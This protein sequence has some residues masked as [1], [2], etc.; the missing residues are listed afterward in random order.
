M[1][2]F[3][4]REALPNWDKQIQGLCVQVNKIIEKINQTQPEWMA[5]ITEQ[6]MTAV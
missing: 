1:F 4:V 2:P 6:E 5:K 3:S